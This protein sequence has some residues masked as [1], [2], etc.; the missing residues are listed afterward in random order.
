DA[1]KMP[2]LQ[3]AAKN[4]LS[5][6]SSATKNTGDVYVS[7][8]PFVKDVNLSPSNYNQSWLLWDDGTDKSWD[9]AK[10]SCSKPGSSKRS[11]CVAQGTC[12]ISANTTQ[13][14]CM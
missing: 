12:S 5:K 2:A 14:T 1:G 3:T 4:M 11:Q 7:I 8:I 6:L 9:G 10:G 13:S